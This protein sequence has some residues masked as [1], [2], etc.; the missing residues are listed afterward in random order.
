M[1][2]LGIGLEL[3]ELVY[4]RIVA[5]VDERKY[6]RI[7]YEGYEQDEEGG[8]YSGEF[9]FALLV[10]TMLLDDTTRTH[11]YGSSGCGD[12]FVCL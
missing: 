5:K 1:D 11:I 7:A 6:E 3:V 2:L 9:P 12:G 4:Y 10:S 8:H